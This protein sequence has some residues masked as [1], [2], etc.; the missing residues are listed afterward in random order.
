[1]P[2]ETAREGDVAVGRPGADVDTGVAE[3]ETHYGGAPA[4]QAVDDHGVPPVD[5]RAEPNVAGRVE[6]SRVFGVEG[7][8]IVNPVPGSPH[9]IVQ[10]RPV[11][12]VP[13]AQ[14]RSSSQLHEHAAFHAVVCVEPHARPGLR[15]RRRVSPVRLP[16]PGV[17]QP[18]LQE[19]GLLQRVGRG[20]VTPRR[21]RPRPR[22][23]ESRELLGVLCELEGV[24]PVGPGPD[25]RLPPQQQLAGTPARREPNDPMD[26]LRPRRHIR[27]SRRRVRSPER[28]HALRPP[29]GGREGGPATAFDVYG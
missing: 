19:I 12:E 8:V 27:G 25:S 28:E 6:P 5:H 2:P 21:S 24:E 22:T 4:R 18:R 9:V 16:T 7:G 1:M 29:D 15:R 26:Q 10:T 17:I 23:R 3:Q 13:A 20:L 11:H 14:Q